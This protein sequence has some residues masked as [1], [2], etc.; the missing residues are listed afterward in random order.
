[1]LKTSQNAPVLRSLCIPL[2]WASLMTV[3]STAHAEQTKRPNFLFLLSDDQRPDTIHAAGNAVIQTPHL[4]KLYASG[5]SFSRAICANPICTPSRAEILTGCSGFRNGVRDFGHKINPK[6]ALWAATLRDAGYRTGYVGKWH[7]DGRPSTRGYQ[8]TAGL[9]TGG[10]GKWAV[11]TF[12][13]NG[14]PVT[15]YRGWIFQT[16]DR[17]LFPEKGIG[18]TPNISEHFAD[19][20]I[21]LI[22]RPSDKPFFLHVNFPAPHDPLLMPFGYEGMYDPNKIPL[23]KNFLP[24]HP[25]DHGNFNGRDEKLLPW[26]RTSKDV[27]DELAVYYAVISHMDAQIGRIMQ[28]LKE[29]GQLENTVVIFSS[30]H[31]LGM[32]SHGLRGKQ[33]MYEHTINV[34]LILSG[35]GIPSGKQLDAQCYLRDLFPTTCQL[36]GVDIPS[37]VQGKSLVPLLSGEAKSIYREVYGQ[38]RD[39]QRMIRTKQWKYIY[40]PHLKKSQLFHLATDPDER[41]NLA[42]NPKHFGIEKKLRKKLQAWQLANDDPALKP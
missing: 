21:G 38:F 33:S 18:L 1:M 9:F 26:P 28:A 6:L 25:F 32:G 7:N 40:Y 39:F 42:G 8:E 30:D 15:G 22:R 4:D 20:A 27:R 13:W 3:V 14:R 31:G 11:P 24:E 23:P 5:T 10:G 19:A 37:T 29:T 2:I 41:T 35:P 36:A 16:D 17:R 12:D 34:P